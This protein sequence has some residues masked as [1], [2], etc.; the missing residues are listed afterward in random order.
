MNEYYFPYDLSIRTYPSVTTEDGEVQLLTSAI[1]VGGRIVLLGQIGKTS[2]CGSAYVLGIYP[3][4]KNDLI[5][6]IRGVRYSIFYFP[7][8][9]WDF[10]ENEIAQE[11]NKN[12]NGIVEISFH[13]TNEGLFMFVDILDVD[14]YWEW[15]E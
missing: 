15:I 13:K 4:Q 3:T 2:C 12:L 9:L 11:L 8:N 6:L 5:E 1:I 10:R 7:G 14:T